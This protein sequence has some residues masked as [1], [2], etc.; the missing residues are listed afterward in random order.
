M[1]ELALFDSFEY[2]CHGATAIRNSLVFQCEDF[3]LD[4]RM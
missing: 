1:S 3:T 4:I 2:L